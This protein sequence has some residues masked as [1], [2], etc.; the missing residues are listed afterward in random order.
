M[1]RQADDEE[2]ARRGASDAGG[3][4]ASDGW[5]GSCGES[6][7]LEEL[8]DGEAAPASLEE[9]CRTLYRALARRLHPDRGERTPHDMGLW[10]AVQ[11]AYQQRDLDRLQILATHAEV[12]R[13]T[14][15]KAT[16]VSALRQL[17]ASFRRARQSLRRVIRESRKDPAWGFQVLDGEAR[18]RREWSM[19]SQL[20]YECDVLRSRLAMME[21]MVAVWQ[22]A[23]PRVR[24]RRAEADAQMMFKL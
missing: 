10:Y 22:E 16:S 3:A 23:P 14:V 15:G 6:D 1:S 4:G 2:E 12:I 13:G 8:G 21:E 20:L 24:R 11:E 19:A 17:E 9:R 18:A 5:G 7:E